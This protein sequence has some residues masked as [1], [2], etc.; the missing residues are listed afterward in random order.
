[1]VIKLK[2]RTKTETNRKGRQYDVPQCRNL[3]RNAY[4]PP[5]PR[6]PHT[7]FYVVR[8]CAALAI[9]AA[10]VLWRIIPL[11]RS[12]TTTTND[13]V[14]FSAVFP[15]V[16]TPPPPSRRPTVET[17]VRVQFPFTTEDPQSGHLSLD[18]DNVSLLIRTRAARPG[19]RGNDIR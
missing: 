14:F 4:V 12:V 10:A 5:G 15:I 1:M 3:P 9:A 8:S 2:L 19:K 6:P 11:G 18:P 16:L 17:V 13:A 7:S